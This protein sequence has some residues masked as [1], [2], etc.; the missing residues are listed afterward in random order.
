MR[1]TG[2]HGL[3]C[4]A[5]CA[6]LR[7]GSGEPATAVRRASPA[8]VLAR[9]ERQ[10]NWRAAAL[11]DYEVTRCYV[12]T[13]TR[14]GN[15][16]AMGVRV[17]YSYPGRKNMEVLW[18]TGSRFLQTRVLR[19][20][21]EA[22]V[23]AARDG[24]RDQTRFNSRNYTFRPAGV[25]SIEGRTAYVYE[26]EP[27]ANRRFLVRGR[28]WID[29]EDAAVARIEGEPLEA[30]SFWVRSVQIVQNY[31]KVGS[32]WLISSNHADAEVRLFGP[33]HLAV[34]YQEYRVN[35]SLVAS[36]HLP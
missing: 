7:V 22:E 31:R 20:V 10:E 8:E 16:A 32:F 30:T 17:N 34:E 24:I 26:L 27:K 15:Q 35:R 13:G 9:F 14:F 23:E 12:L 19:R 4:L 5:F 33:A 29:A 3:G 36:R 2:W 11:R 6:M 18:T 21:L 25:E 28:I 1:G